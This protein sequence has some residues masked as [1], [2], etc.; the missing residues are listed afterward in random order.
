MS[1]RTRRI[2]ATAAVAAALLTGIVAAPADAAGSGQTRVTPAQGCN[3]GDYAY[4]S[5]ASSGRAIAFTSF[6]GYCWGNKSAGARAIAGS[7]VSSWQYNWASVTVTIA[8][9]PSATVYGNHS[10]N[11]GYVRNT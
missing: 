5:Y 6:D 9:P 7:A 3:A 4:R 11:G 1:L 8:K 10:I 2:A